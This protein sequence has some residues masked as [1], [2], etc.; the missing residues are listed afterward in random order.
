ME[1]EK[2]CGALVY[3]IQDSALQLLLIKHKQGGH[4][5]F[6][7]GHVEENETEIQTAIREVKEETGVSIQILDGFR[8]QVNYSPRFGVR[9][10]VVYFLGFTEDK[11]T[12]R[13]ESEI[14]ELSW[15]SLNNAQHYLTYE[16]DRKSVV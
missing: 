8:Q 11:T 5:S 14:S 12:Q 10:D 9:K 13:Q 15:V 6:P 2:S 1:N 4:W 3:C 7:K 16:K